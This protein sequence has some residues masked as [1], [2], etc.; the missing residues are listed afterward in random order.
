MVPDSVNNTP[1]ILNSEFFLLPDLGHSLPYYI[2]IAEGKKRSI[3]AFWKCISVKRKQT[4][5]SRILTQLINSISHNDNHY[6]IYSLSHIFWRESSNSDL[7]IFFKNIWSINLQEKNN[8]NNNN[9]KTNKKN[10][11]KTKTNT[12]NN[13]SNKK[14]DL[15]HIE[16]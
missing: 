6:V 1:Q 13:F 7:D 10:K 4:A 8:N 11:N 2:P 16:E 9:K 12:Y 5:L 3:H 14:D 15:K